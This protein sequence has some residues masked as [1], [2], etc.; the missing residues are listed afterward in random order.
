MALL[1]IKKQKKGSKNMDLIR[2]F[3]TFLSYYSYPILVFFL[4]IYKKE[5]NL[6]RD[7]LI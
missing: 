4:I 1:F 5:E 6:N 3:R 7:S 2:T